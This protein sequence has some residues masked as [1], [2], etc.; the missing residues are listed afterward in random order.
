MNNEDIF[1]ILR[2]FS[3]A[4]QQFENNPYTPK[5]LKLKRESE[6]KVITSGKWKEFIENHPNELFSDYIASE[7]R[8]IAGDEL[9]ELENNEREYSIKQ[10]VELVSGLMGNFRQK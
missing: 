2:G 8:K 5:I 9:L 4:K 10:G 6:L 3:D 7:G 1:G